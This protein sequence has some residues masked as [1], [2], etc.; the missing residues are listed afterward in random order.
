LKDYNNV[1]Q[2]TRSP[3]FR[4]IRREENIDDS[5]FHIWKSELQKEL[6]IFWEEM[7]GIK[8]TR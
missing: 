7:S 6:P 8:D 5:T 2:K 3:F 4:G 1:I